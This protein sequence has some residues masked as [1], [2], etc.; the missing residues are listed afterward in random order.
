M[1]RAILE[2]R[3]TQTRRIIKKVKEGPDGFLVPDNGK[4]IVCPYGQPV[5]RLW[6][7]ETWARNG[8]RVW[9][10]ASDPQ[11]DFKW[12]P[13]IH[14]K[15]GYSRIDLEVLKV[16]VERLQDISE[17]DAKSEGVEP[18]KVFQKNIIKNF[19]LESRGEYYGGFQQIWRRINGGG[20]W[21]IN[22]WVWVVEFR[23]VRP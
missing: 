14:M 11:L 1:V 8:L 21:E 7:R 15:R 5:D 19:L 16:G 10:K 9:F 13:S 6:V 2:G 23:R 20:S 3:K 17:E 12:H 18:A 4:K 22:P